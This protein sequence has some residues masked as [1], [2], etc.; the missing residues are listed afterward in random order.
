[1]KLGRVLSSSALL[2]LLQISPFL[3]FLLMAMFSVNKFNDGQFF[4][5]YMKLYGMALE[6][7]SI[8]ATSILKPDLGMKRW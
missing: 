3:K 2:G 8:I 5:M 6:F 7:Q 4:S 1:M